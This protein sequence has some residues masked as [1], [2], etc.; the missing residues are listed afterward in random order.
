M[1]PCS[2]FHADVH[3]DRLAGGALGSVSLSSDKMWKMDSWLPSNDELAMS[4]VGGGVDVGLVTGLRGTHSVGVPAV[5]RNVVRRSS[6][7]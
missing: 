4:V 3:V 5:T 2:V 7:P 1:T 6:E